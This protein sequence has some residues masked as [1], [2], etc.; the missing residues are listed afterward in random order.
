MVA[1]RSKEPQTGG[2][3]RWVGH[4]E[5]GPRQLNNRSPLLAAP[6]RNLRHFPSDGGAAGSSAY[7]L[8]PH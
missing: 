4:K 2:N 7:G 8:E 3:G 5:A 1:I 6:N